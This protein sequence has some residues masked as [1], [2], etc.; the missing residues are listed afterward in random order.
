MLTYRLP[1]LHRFLLFLFLVL[2]PIAWGQAAESADTPP[3]VAATEGASDAEPPLDEQLGRI[4]DALENVTSRIEGYAEDAPAPESLSRLEDLLQTIEGVIQR[5]MTLSDRVE[6]SRRERDDQLQRRAAFEESGFEET[7]PYPLA[8]VDALRDEQR[9]AKRGRDTAALARSMTDR[10]VTRAESEYKDAQTA[11]RQARDRLES[12]DDAERVTLQDAYTIS[13][14]REDLARQR[15]EAARAEREVAE[16]QNRIAEAR[17]AFL[18]EKV[19]RA[20]AQEQFTEEAL[21]ARL[22]E[23]EKRRADLESSLAALRREKDRR[24]RDL[25]RSRE[26]ARA[27][28]ENGEQTLLNET[29]AAH[30]AAFEAAA[31]GVDFVEQRLVD[32]G[33]EQQL[34]QRRYD[35]LQGQAGDQLPAWRTEAGDLIQELERRRDLLE[36]RLNGLRSTQLDLANRLETNEIESRVAQQLRARADA[37][38]TLEGRAR[39]YL[40]S[41]VSVQQLAQRLESQL[42]DR[43]AVLGLKDQIARAYRVVREAWDREAFVLDDRGFTVGKLAQALIVFVVVIVVLYIGRSVFRRTVAKR[44]LSL[45]SDNAPLYRLVA[46]VVIR[47]TRKYIVALIAIYCGLWVLPLSETQQTILNNGVKV[48]LLVQLAVYVS[49][50]VKRL[51]ERAGKRRSVEDPGS[52]TSFGLMSFFGRMAIW[53]LTFLLALRTLD[54]DITPLVAGF[55]IGGVAVAFALQNILGDIFCSVA[56]LLDKPFVVGD[57]II[58]GDQMGVVENIGL[59]TTRVRALGGEQ[60]VFSNADLLGSRIRNYKRMYERRVVFML[61]VVY[62]TR[63]EA[64]RKIP[65][66][67][68]GIIEQQDRIRFDR[69]HFAR[70]GDFSLDFETVYYVL[71]ADYN[72]YMDIQQAIN[73]AIFDAF[74]A[75]GISFAYPT[76][77]IIMRPQV[78]DGEN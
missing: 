30:E 41:V 39:E 8:F 72:L 33:T 3:P 4:R 7:P 35:L 5:R 63:P 54:Y 34:W 45:Q 27:T 37:L 21:A 12:A 36:T 16:I 64:L 57:F 18:A 15:L 47:E 28:A 43:I 25:A 20:A 23:L 58:V 77:E 56:I 48:L 32:V 71:D 14:R 9:A 19:G 31:S 73:L 50:L 29:V 11:R 66:I 61:G 22:D 44:L 74:A 46:V 53:V 17:V 26:A 1:V 67:I 13:Q 65:G 76:R 68:Q 2:P 38:E 78:A 49:A 24:E 10:A 59:K 69:C 6:E 42:L 62:E 55:G 52:V 60:I 51:I 75:E 40:S 70:Y